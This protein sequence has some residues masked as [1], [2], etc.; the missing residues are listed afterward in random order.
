MHM[1]IVSQRAL[2]PF[3]SL[4]AQNRQQV[5]AELVNRMNSFG[6]IRKRFAECFPDLVLTEVYL[7]R[8]RL[9][10]QG[11]A[12]FI[13]QDAGFY[14]SGVA[15]IFFCQLH[16]GSIAFLICYTEIAPL[17][18]GKVRQ[19]ESCGRFGSAGTGFDGSRLTHRLSFSLY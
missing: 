7:C 12:W 13:S 2:A 16:E 15:H 9:L 19:C 17:F 18:S 3:V 1:Q 8:N 4:L 10:P 14:C 11:T 5:I 6:Q